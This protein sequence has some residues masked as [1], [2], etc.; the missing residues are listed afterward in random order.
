VGRGGVEQGGVVVSSWTLA[1]VMLIDF[2]SAGF[3]YDETKTNILFDYLRPHVPPASLMVVGPEE[4]QK[5]R[6]F[7]F[8]VTDYF[9][10]MTHAT[11]PTIRAGGMGQVAAQI[12][13]HL[14]VVP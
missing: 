7:S 12:V 8:K 10:H 2:A 5:R 14:K 1:I 6:S 3:Y 9:S 13:S 11:C 4:V